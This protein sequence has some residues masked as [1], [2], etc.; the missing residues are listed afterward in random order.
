MRD[1][2]HTSDEKQ[3]K[4]SI[5]GAFLAREEPDREYMNDLKAQWS[6]MN[7]A[8]RRQFILGAVIGLLIFIG[9]VGLVLFLILKLMG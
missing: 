3:R 5:L 7:S 1:K 4:K 8:E 2:K 9:L 6:I